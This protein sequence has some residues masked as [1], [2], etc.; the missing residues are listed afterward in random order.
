M[1]PWV[2]RVFIHILPRLLIMKRPQYQN[3]KHGLWGSSAKVNGKT[4]A[5][6]DG[7]QVPLHEYTTELSSLY[8]PDYAYD[9][10]SIQPPL[11]ADDFTTQ[12]ADS[13]F[14]LTCR[15]HGAKNIHQQDQTD[16]PEADPSQTDV[17]GAV[18]FVSSPTEAPAPKILPF[19]TSLAHD[20]THCSMEV[21]RACWCVNFIAE[22]TRCK[23]DSTK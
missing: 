7:S 18:P 20:L 10:T 13:G 9:A 12:L 17:E 16:Q 19:G 22:H 21:H 2:R 3:N 8:K 14:P 6:S 4:A 23:E 5:N 11:L 15:I 1:A